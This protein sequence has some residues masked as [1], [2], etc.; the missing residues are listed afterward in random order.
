M[1]AAHINS[2]FC[3]RLF[4]PLEF[5]KVSIIYTVKRRQLSGQYTL[6]TIYQAFCLSTCPAGC[7]YFLQKVH[8][9]CFVSR[10]I[11]H[12]YKSK[13]E[14]SYHDEG[15]V[16]S[17]IFSPFSVIL[18]AALTPSAWESLPYKTSEPV[19]ANLCAWGSLPKWM[20]FTHYGEGSHH[21]LHVFLRFC[22]PYFSLIGNVLHWWG[23]F[24][25][26]V[27]PSASQ[28]FPVSFSTHN[29]EDINWSILELFFFSSFMYINHVYKRLIF[30]FWQ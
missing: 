4:I 8:P 29:P 28:V 15:R 27:W 2:R 26:Q 17:F 14:T 10:Y 3:R 20:F 16:V 24:S 11:L 13:R 12:A 23:W 21:F 25:V 5:A 1:S 6:T 19:A 30:E 9:Q 22:G 18:S 7:F